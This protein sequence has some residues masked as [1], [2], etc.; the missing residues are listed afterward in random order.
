MGCLSRV[1]GRGVACRGE[2]TGSRAGR[3]RACRGGGQWVGGPVS[4]GPVVAVPLAPGIMD[5]VIYAESL[6]LGDDLLPLLVLALGGA[7]LVGNVLALAR[8]PE[9][10][11]DGE[12]RR[13][14][15]GRSLVM[16]SSA[17]SPPCG[18]SAAC[19]ATVPAQLTASVPVAPGIVIDRPRLRMA[20]AAGPK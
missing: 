16:A 3:G 17:W 5:G 20:S 19:S 8:P 14:P 1:A 13:A 10:P 12:L 11:K 9:R 18:R 7:L 15:T 4:G 6:I 2:A